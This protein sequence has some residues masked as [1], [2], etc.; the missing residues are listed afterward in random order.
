MPP[1]SARWHPRRLA[2]RLPA[3]APARAIALGAGLLL[4]LIAGL[5]ALLG[6][7][8]P[9]EALVAERFVAAW[10]RG[11][12]A[13]MHAQLSA[14]SRRATPLAE[15]AARYRRSAATATALSL[16]AGRVGEPR[17]GAIAVQ[18]TVRTRLFGPVRETLSLP[19]E[20]AGDKARIDWAPN[21]TFPGVRRGDRLQRKTSLP[22]RADILARDGRP[23]AQGPE[24]S[25]ALDAAAT[26]IVGRLEQLPAEDRA[27]LRELGYP[28][29]ARV[30]VSGLERV[31]EQRL[32]GRPGGVL[33]AGGT[34]LGSSRPRA[35]AAVRTTIDPKVQRTAVAALGERAGG[36]AA[37]G[38]RDGEILA[39]SGAAFS[40]LS[41]P[42]STF[43]IVTLAG[44]LQAGVTRPGSSYP[45]QTK[46]QLEGVD[47]QNANGESCGG[48]L[49]A[50][51]AH[52]CNSVFAPM[53]AKLGA[54]RLVRAAEAFGF[55][56][57]L[58]IPG[59]EKST[60]PPADEIGD[61][62][63]VGSSA[64]GQGKV[65]ATALQM[66]LV[67]STIAD[68]GRRPKLTL[69]RDAAPVRKRAFP[70]RTARIVARYMEAVVREGTGRAAAIG[71]V[72][73]AGKTGTAELRSTQTSSC[74]PSPEAP[75]PAPQPDDPTDTNAWFAA[76]APA[77]AP[78]VAVGVLL[79]ASGVGGE[80]AAPVAREVLLAGLRA[81][82]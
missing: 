5:L 34:L 67:A 10:E 43:K 82:R 9:A 24:R 62:L 77:R 2:S 54:Q 58:G 75:C 49:R 59:A 41:P 38:P 44:A 71:G 60:I 42:G 39:L 68:R 18:V 22:A 28:S 20:G 69:D 47:V 63:A 30:G 52:S 25:S 74:V 3:R 15:L 37:V 50:S 4:A 80:S 21:L 35:G 36:V 79:V 29:D 32:A 1:A 31:F 26:S 16:K 6:G 66:A 23:L 19:L 17:E 70:A 81:T 56:E 78:R 64:I 48:T 8:R 72:R 51:F 61:D 27:R 40:G 53:G 57:D 12:F 13:A 33:R 65:Q 11:D 76:F 46:T 73:V 14:D 45:V 7:G 55:N